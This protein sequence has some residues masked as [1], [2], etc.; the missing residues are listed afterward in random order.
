MQSKTTSS[1]FY[2]PKSTQLKIPVVGQETEILSL[3]QE[4]TSSNNIDPEK[5]KVESLYKYKQQRS[6]TDQLKIFTEEL[7]QLQTSQHH[8]QD[9]LLTRSIYEE[10]A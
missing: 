7:A 8:R 6:P 2:S 5:S 10:I 3:S 9:V 1:N 4:K